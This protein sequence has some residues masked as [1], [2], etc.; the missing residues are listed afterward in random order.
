M[1]LRDVAIIGAGPAGIAAA[2]QLKRYGI[3]PLIFER[4]S[5]GGLL[6][7]AD[8]VENYPGFPHGISGRKLI[9]A[10]GKHLGDSDQTCFENVIE[11]DFEDNLFSVISTGR[12]IQSRI[13]IVASG[14]LPVVFSDISIP[15]ELNDRIFYEIYP[16]ME[17]KGKRIAI[18]GAGDAAFDYALNLGRK[19]EVYILNRSDRT[20]CLP[21]L[22]ERAEK[23]DKISH[24]K[25]AVLSAIN[26]GFDDLLSITY[27][28]DGNENELRANYLVFAIGRKPAVGF[29][30]DRLNNHKNRLVTDS[31]LYM[32]GDVNNGVFRQTAIAVG[33]GIKAAMK[34]AAKLKEIR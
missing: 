7:N 1:A 26:T 3:V 16:I 34:I 21:L 32:I 30:S 4:D 31:L 25:N 14:T 13:A 33:D 27:L 23:S 6:K 5:I 17:E 24:I 2:I 11:L 8:I 29:F 19:S 10:L 15:V 9:T 12:T 20:S 22:R 28:R 18:V